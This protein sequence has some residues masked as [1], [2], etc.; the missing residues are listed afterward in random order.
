M[1]L[2]IIYSLM[3]A[4]FAGLVAIF[5]KIGL[6]DVDSTLA[7][8][9]RAFVMAL[10]LLVISLSLGKLNL[11]GTIKSKALTFIILS[12]VAGALSWLFYFLALKTGIASGVAALD[13]LSVVFVVIFAILFLGEKL[14]WFTAIGA[15]L[16]TAGAILMVIK[17]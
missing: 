2:W 13:R 16:I 10:F 3:A 1:Q 4:A 9:V 8:T 15:L 12:G 11:L 17:K 5:G 14:N 6:K 7:T